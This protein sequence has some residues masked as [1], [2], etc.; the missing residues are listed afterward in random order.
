MGE[1]ASPIQVVRKTPKEN[2]MPARRQALA[3][4]LAHTGP[5]RG[6]RNP[7]EGPSQSRVRT[8]KRRPGA[9]GLRG[10]ITQPT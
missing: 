8:E 1:G 2:G 5:S 7:E 4:A 9:S 6:H 3:C 10:T